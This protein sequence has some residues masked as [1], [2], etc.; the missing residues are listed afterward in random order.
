M[1]ISDG[2]EMAAPEDNAAVSA[3][4]ES[5]ETDLET[6][7]DDLGEAGEGEDNGDEPPAPEDDQEEVEFEG[8][9]YRV[10][11]DLK[12]ALMMRADYTRK[13]QEVAELRKSAEAEIA[14]QRELSKE[15]LRDRGQLAMIE[16]TLEKYK[17]VDWERWAQEDPDACN[18][19]MA[20][21]RT[22]ENR[23]AMIEGSVKERETKAAESARAALDKQITEVRET[24][25][26]DIPGWGPEKAQQI[27]NF[28]VENGADPAVIANLIDP[29][30]IKFLHMAFVGQQLMKAS[31]SKGKAPAAA[32]AQASAAPVKAP[33]PLQRVGRAPAAP[34]NKLS[35][36]A[37]VDDWMKARTAQVSKHKR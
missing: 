23:K 10:P 30:A 1:T 31:Q 8:K 20:Q 27:R 3:P 2:G 16:D 24:L 9:K 12:G 7:E 5:I 13:T 35:E 33:E 22:L 21:L 11:R 18:R 37:P 14:Q 36:R 6:N 25:V 26:R 19:G 32:G 17:N 4:S 15:D 34:P 28:A 29:V